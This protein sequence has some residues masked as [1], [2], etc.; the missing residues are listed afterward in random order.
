[1]NKIKDHG[2]KKKTI[3]SIIDRKIKHWVKTINNE[4]LRERILNDYIVTGGSIVSMLHGELPNDFDVYFQT[5]EVALDVANYYLTNAGSSFNDK[6]KK[7][8]ARLENNRVR[9]FIK[10]AGIIQGDASSLNNY[11]YFEGRE[12][13]AAEAFL[14]NA[15]L[16]KNKKPYTPLMITDNAIT[17]NDSIQIITRFIG[18]PEE[19]HKNFDFVHTTNYYTVKTG[20]VLKQ[21]ALEAIIAKELKYVGSLYPLCSMFRLKKFIKRGWSVSAGEML[22]IGFDISRLD[23]TNTE[24]LRE[25]CIGVDAAYFHQLLRILEQNKNESETFDRTYLVEMINKVFD[26]MDPDD[27]SIEE[28]IKLGE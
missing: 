21:D 17:L 26:S 1:M 3:A 12:S 11:D 18:N 9:I 15:G 16:E 14:N 27:E 4:Q 20:L 2:F 8:E 25:Q 19:I 5:P 6:A 23:L 7:I 22:K 13:G 10:S 24:I 28:M